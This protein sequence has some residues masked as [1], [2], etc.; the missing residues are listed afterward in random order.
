VDTRNWW[1][2]KKVVLSPESIKTV[3]WPDSR[4]HVDLRRDEIETAPA[5]APGRPLDRAYETRLLEHHSRRKC[6]EWEGR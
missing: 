4:V 3:S 6:W 2:G 5:Y 1:P